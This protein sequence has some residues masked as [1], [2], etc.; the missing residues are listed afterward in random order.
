MI[1]QGYV[2]LFDEP[3]DRE[4][5]AGLVESW[6]GAGLQVEQVCPGNHA[7]NTTLSLKSPADIL[8]EQ[9]L[10]FRVLNG[11]T[12]AWAYLSLDRRVVETSGMPDEGI[13]LPLEILAELPGLVEVVDQINERR[14]D[15]LEAEGLL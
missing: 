9:H 4:G 13:T 15:Q 1:S 14:L 12:F 2:G 5:V 10:Q 7:G 8:W 11:V 3:F 6:L